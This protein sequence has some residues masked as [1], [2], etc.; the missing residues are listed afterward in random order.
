MRWHEKAISHS[1]GAET[2]V[3]FAELDALPF[4]AVSFVHDHLNSLCPELKSFLG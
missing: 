4:D 1:C 2:R 3:T